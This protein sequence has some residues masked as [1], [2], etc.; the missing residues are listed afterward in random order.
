[1]LND[2]RCFQENMNL[3]EACILLEHIL[4]VFNKHYLDIYMYNC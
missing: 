1:M 3:T 2:N 4:I